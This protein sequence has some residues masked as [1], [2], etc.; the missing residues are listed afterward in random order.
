MTEIV[1]K[2]LSFKGYSLKTWAIKN[3]FEILKTAGSIVVLGIAYFEG[4]SPVLAGVIGLIT[5]F[6]LDALD[7]FLTEV[8]K[9]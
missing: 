9:E 2:S 3:K 7:Y 5:K 6:G 1:S 4:V 8:P